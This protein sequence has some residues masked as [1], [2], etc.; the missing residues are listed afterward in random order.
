M[1]QRLVTFGCLICLFSGA[2][3][4]RANEFTVYDPGEL[5][6][7]SM[8]CEA[9]R[10]PKSKLQ[11]ANTFNLHIDVN[12]QGKRAVISTGANQDRTSMALTGVV[13]SSQRSAG[14]LALSNG[15]SSAIVSTQHRDISI[16]YSN[17]K[18]TDLQS[19]TGR[20]CK[21]YDHQFAF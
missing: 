1:V 16:V 12:F 10:Y 13:P 15:S 2:S 21:I 6:N 5:T 19:I 3:E 8:D 20:N 4:A 11:Q 18:R 14:Y 17:P 7:I 9:T